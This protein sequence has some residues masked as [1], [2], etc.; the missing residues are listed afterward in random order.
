[1]LFFCLLYIILLT[2]TPLNIYVV[3][4]PLCG[5]SHSQL[6]ILL[7]LEGNINSGYGEHWYY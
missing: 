3:L 7:F 6:N 5:L 1:M 2:L 4:I